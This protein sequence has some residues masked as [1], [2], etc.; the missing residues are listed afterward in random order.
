MLKHIFFLLC[1]FVVSLHTQ[2]NSTT[3]QTVTNDNNGTIST[4]KTS[5]VLI[6]TTNSTTNGSSLPAVI[7]LNQNSSTKITTEVNSTS[8]PKTI[9]IR[10][11]SASLSHQLDIISKLISIIL[12][13]N[14]ARLCL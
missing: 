2:N 10:N 4:N 12:F 6:T 13:T 9:F 11:N 3:N 7:T 1:L 5:V 14:F 8:A